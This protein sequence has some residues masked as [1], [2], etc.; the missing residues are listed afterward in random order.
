VYG[1]QRQHANKDEDKRADKKIPAL[2]AKS[3]M[4]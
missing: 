1:R 4:T 3:A 2:I